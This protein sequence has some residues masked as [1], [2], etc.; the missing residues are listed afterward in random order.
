MFW[1]SFFFLIIVFDTMIWSII[2]FKICCSSWP[3]SFKSSNSDKTFLFS[4]LNETTLWKFNSVCKLN[5]NHHFFDPWNV[6]FVTVLSHSQLMVQ[7]IGR[8]HKLFL[9]KWLQNT[10]LNV[11]KLQNKGLGILKFS[12]WL[13]LQ[14]MTFMLGINKYSGQ[15]PFC[16]ENLE[17]IP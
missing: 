1:E 11:T 6:P 4:A 7:Q 5:S 13:L 2:F 9:N 15:F 14:Q 10:A 16:T 8:I 17:L 12:V 3:A